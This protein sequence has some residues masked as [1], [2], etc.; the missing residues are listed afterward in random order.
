[1][2]ARQSGARRMSF[3]FAGGMNPEEGVGIAWQPVG[4][5][6]AHQSPHLPLVES[7]RKDAQVVDLPAEF[8]GNFRVRP[9]AE[10][11]W[12]RVL[13]VDDCSDSLVVFRRPGKPEGQKDKAISEKFTERELRIV[14]QFISN[15]GFHYFGSGKFFALVGESFANAILDLKKQ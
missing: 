1:M 9:D 10:P 15:K 3:D 12:H 4:P 5:S 8:T 6:L 13:A 2:A 14:N 7:P 11:Q